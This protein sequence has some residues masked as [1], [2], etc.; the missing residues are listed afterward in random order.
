MKGNDIA[1]TGVGI[2]SSIGNNVEDFDKAL[3]DM[4]S[5]L[6]KYDSPFL[7]V[8]GKISDFDFDKA[9]VFDTVPPEIKSKAI[10]LCRRSG[11]AV[12][13]TVVA[14]LEAY[15][16]ARVQDI[17]SEDVSILT[18]GSNLAQGTIYEVY[19]KAFDSPEFVSPSYATWYF[20]TNING[21]LSELLGINGEG[22]SIGAAS[23]S[24][25]VCLFQGM[26]MIRQGDTKVC[27]CVSP[28]FDFSEVELSAF[29]NL[30]ALGDYSKFKDPVEA[31]RPF[32]E[33]HM[34]FVPG[35]AS[36][37]IVL[38]DCQSARARGCEI[39]ALLSGGS[40]NLDG[41][42]LP[43]ASE[44]GELKAMTRALSDAGISVADIDYINAHG[45]STPAGDITEANAIERL[46]GEH[47]DKVYINSTKS[48]T[49]H[50]LYSAGMVEAL[51]TVCQMR[52]DYIHG[53]RN[54]KNPVLD[55]L[56]FARETEKNCHIT[57][58]LSNSFGFGGINSS[59]V[60]RTL[61][62]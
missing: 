27:I 1:I 56:K 22:M 28:L 38:E 32:D 46:L 37:C 35:Q 42:H 43:N 4:Q 51:A 49:G 40:M 23:A 60:I 12:K 17:S 33:G 55:T 36:V 45:T 24:G 30:Q 57:Y 19:K 15:F 41:N 20:N 29:S 2:V 39:L 13:T 48:L 58:A 16:K 34:G 62:N 7:K 11:L 25:N 50:C 44:E 52:G 59:L 9:P 31:C 18:A 6:K 54:L 47:K 3:F 21:I 14:A 5:G 61:D 26:R 10:S 53:I 8:I